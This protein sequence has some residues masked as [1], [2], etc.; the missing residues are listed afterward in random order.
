MG[1]N[2][3]K[4]I[5][6]TIPAGDLVGRGPQLERLL[7][8]AERE[9]PC[10]LALLA[11]PG[12]GTSELLRQVYDHLFSANGEY[13]PFYFALQASDL[14]PRG[15]AQ[16]FL[17]DLLTQT[18][19]FRSNDPS[20]VGS[21]PSLDELSDLAR[22]ADD[23]WIDP[24][25]RT[26]RADDEGEDTRAFIRSLVS[27]PLRAS[28]HGSKFFVMIDDVELSLT[29]PAG[30]MF[31]NELL[32]VYGR[33]GTGYIFAGARRF[34]YGKLAAET[35]KLGP[36]D[37]VTSCELCDSLG[38][39]FDVSLNEQTRDL[40]AVQLGG[41]P[42]HMTSLFAAAAEKETGLDDFRSVETVYTDEIFGGRIGRHYDK[43][44]ERIVPESARSTVTRLLAEGLGSP[45]GTVSVDHWRKRLRLPE[46]AFQDALSLLNIFEFVSVNAGKVFSE[47]SDLVL[48]DH[49]LGTTRLADPQLTRAFVVGEAMTGNLARAPRLMAR[50]YRRN[51]ALGLRVL[52]GDF[53]GQEVATA[54]IDYGKY[55][56][57]LKGL[58]DSEIERELAASS[59]SIALPQI[60][61]TAHTSAF[62]SPI[63]E[64]IEDERSTI[65]L[66]FEEADYR[67]RA[68]WLA[69]EIDSKLEADAETTEFWCDRLEMVA[70]SCGF[71]EYKLWLIAPEG[72]SD[73]ALEILRSRSAYGSSRKQAEMLRRILESGEAAEK[74]PAKA[75]EYEIV[76]PM[77]Q[78]T[79]M[80]AA[81]AVED[82]AKRHNV[83][84]RTINQ[85]KTALVEACIN[86]TEHSLSP[87]QRIFQKIAIDDQ[88]V[89]ITIANRG[90]RL[91]DRQPTEASPDEGRR[92][93]GLRLLK[94]LM[95]DVRIDQTDDGTRITMVKNLKVA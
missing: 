16:R 41:Y 56:A 93:W 28:A 36:L 37:F 48:S 5:L 95:D 23:Y 18:I 15:T 73:Q 27:A 42:S 11:S 58:S 2:S 94:E 87:D 85:I 12:S 33:S 64:L 63:G 44:L 30:E 25:I 92:G 88:K 71:E 19:A 7:A 55:K 70:V 49:I 53:E 59:D 4:R 68:V 60:V 31:L 67:D 77:G 34:L 86:A 66:G 80:I 14:E 40:I 54:A 24:L 39:R 74:K 10:G 57:S 38:S 65:A 89:T 29:T 84:A 81:H 35:I 75:D 13:I 22:S 91:I 76:I 9:T 43:L 21:A 17:H 61:Y 50:L 20:I 82:I 3:V 79:E 62:Y 1:E 83:P 46:P 26:A 78:D 69:A 47:V 32:D 90:L 51:A 45:A 6:G 52:L 8:H 72:F